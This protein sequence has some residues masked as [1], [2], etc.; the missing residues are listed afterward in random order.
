[1]GNLTTFGLNVQDTMISA[2]AKE[3]EGF[4]QPQLRSHEIW[5]L[6]CYIE[7]DALKSLIDA[8]SERVRLTYVAIY[9]N[10]AEALKYRVNESK[11]LVDVL[12]ELIEEYKGDGI[13]VEWFPIHVP[14]KL[15]HAKAYAVVQWDGQRDGIRRGCLLT[16]SGNLTSRGLGTSD[17]MNVE[18]GYQ[19]N[20]K[21]DLWAFSNLLEVLY[22]NYSVDITNYSFNEDYLFKYA[23]LSNAVYLYRWQGNLVS[24]MSLRF[25]LNESKKR[26]IV[27]VN[28]EL[29]SMGFHSDENSLSISRNYINLSGKPNNPFPSNYRK[30][31]CIET[32]IGYW[33]PRSIWNYTKNV[34]SNNMEHFINWFHERTNDDALKKACEEAKQHEERLLK[35]GFIKR[36]KDRLKKWKKKIRGLRRDEARLERLHWQYECFEL[37]YDVTNQDGIEELYESLTGTIQ[38]KEKRFMS[39]VKAKR[40]ILSRSLEALKL[41]DDDKEYIDK[42]FSKVR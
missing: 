12:D 30:L 26:D 2:I 39:V 23:L 7:A 37:P 14:G 9:F 28:E 6:T 32:F 33:C 25:T 1:M 17:N 16:T 3:I 10:Y 31:L 29:V 20:T 35:L 4:R 8:V 42:I 36:N 38:L 34:V 22:E 40:A 5:A 21:K 11:Q 27:K 15:V 24:E 41:G 19:S 18:I 13:T